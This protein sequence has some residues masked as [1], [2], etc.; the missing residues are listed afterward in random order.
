M[1]AGTKFDIRKMG[2]MHVSLEKPKSKGFQ[3]SE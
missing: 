2:T 1:L 3:F